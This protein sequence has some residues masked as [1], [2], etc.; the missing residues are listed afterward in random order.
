MKNTDKP[1]NAR[2]R[3]VPFRITAE[4]FDAWKG[5]PGRARGVLVDGLGK[6]Y[7]K[8]Q[9]GVAHDSFDSLASLIRATTNE[10]ERTAEGAKA[11]VASPFY[12]RMI[13][14]RPR[15]KAML[16]EVGA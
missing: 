7:P 5:T 15:L 1:L 2:P 14:N 10:D 6:F 11:V 3:G 13:R 8:G 9:R 16:A 4:N 12:A